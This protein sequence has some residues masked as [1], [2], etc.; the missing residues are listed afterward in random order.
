MKVLAC[1]GV[2]AAAVN[3]I[4]EAGHEVVEAKGLAGPTLIAALQ[5]VQGLLV[6]SAT[7]VTAEVLAGTPDLKEI[8]RAHV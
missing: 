4:R 7:T 3:R 6:R 1:D 5:D 2:D 8:G